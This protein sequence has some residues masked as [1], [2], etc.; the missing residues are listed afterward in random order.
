MIT[1]KDLDRMVQECFH[2]N[3]TSFE[4]DFENWGID[5]EA[6]EQVI[7][8]LIRG[9]LQDIFKE[10][11]MEGATAAIESS[12]AVGFG[13]GFKCAMELEMQRLVEGN[14]D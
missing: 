5:P 2:D 4:E 14:D 3:S 12:I 13:I 6:M 10:R 9:T 1:A 7:M 11:T 8:L